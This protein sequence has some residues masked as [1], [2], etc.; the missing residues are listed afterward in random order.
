MD[1]HCVRLLELDKV[2]TRLLAAA[3][4]EPGRQLVQQLRPSVEHD[5]LQGWLQET[6]EAVICLT[7]GHS[8]SWAGLRDICKWVQAAAKGMVADVEALVQIGQGAAGARLLHTA[9]SSEWTEAIPRLHHLAQQIQPCT[10]LE[11]ALQRALDFDTK[12]IKDNASLDLLRARKAI[13]QIQARIQDQLR[14]LL[15]DSRIQPLLQDAFIT[16]RDG[17]YCVPVKAECR[18]Q[19]PGIVHDRSGSG[20]AFFV[21]PQ[22]IVNLNNDLREQELAEAAAAHQVLIDLTALVAE[23]AAAL[24]RN[25]TICAQL[26]FAC[27]KG[28]LALQMEAVEP[29]LRAPGSSPGYC[30]LQARHPLLDPCVANDIRLGSGAGED[31]FDVMLITGPNTGGK[32]IVLKTLGLLVLMTACGLHIP[33][34]RGSE[35]TVPQCV[36]A[37]I[38]DEQSIEQSLSTF[39]S[40]LRQIARI[41]RE[42]GRGDLVLLDEIGAGTDPDE[43]A[44]LAK[45][46]LRTLQRRGVQVVATTHYGELKK[47]ALSAAR[48]QNA[49]VEFDPQ[50]LRPTYRLRIG[51]PG[52]SNALEIAIRLG[53]PHGLV[54]RARRYVG[55]EREEAALATA[56]L[57]ATHRVMEQHSDQLQEERAALARQK[58]HYDKELQQLKQQY[59]EAIQQAYREAAGVAADTQR[60]AEQILRQL[61]LAEREGKTTEQARGRLRSLQEK[62]AV[63]PVIVSLPARPA[64]EIAPAPELVP[65]TAAG[66]IGVGSLVRVPHLQREGVVLTDPDE[67]NQIEIRIGA[68][69]IKTAMQDVVPVVPRTATPGLPA[70]Q[71]RKS[72]N[73]HQELNLIGKTVDEALPLL[74]KYLDDAL[75]AEASPVRVVHGRGSGIL[76]QAV[77]QFLRGYRGVS[78]FE[79]APAAEGG[80]G[81]TVV[82]LE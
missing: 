8:I 76:R 20:N 64:I 49:S 21:E 50:S 7:S 46:V 54:Q 23:D 59:Q 68:M 77:H 28:R 18:N 14:R 25:Q 34:A 58:A 11:A 6:S 5:V 1:Q 62:V 57:E 75:L 67:S 52:T 30:L 80:D 33:V 70:L 16:I 27:A 31:G 47:F 45:A 48:F 19:L 15:S 35:L 55:V 71:M 40:H 36:F 2:L 74:D 39:S 22:T 32:T 53:L 51:I 44:A 29:L 73:L 41:L 43:G 37:D 72:L 78:R 81:A 63:K 38:G 61:R 66:T 82:F 65:E 24:L 42:A 26:D 79:P 3:A 60:E 9:L 10:A 12:S 13:R 17:R 4:T 56:R 69:K